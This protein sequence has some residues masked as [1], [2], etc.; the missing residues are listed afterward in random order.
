MWSQ[1]F[2]TVMQRF[3]YVF[4][5]KDNKGTNSVSQMYQTIEIDEK[6]YKGVN[7]CMTFPP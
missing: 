7:G 4:V 5:E 2:G 1:N 6:E 3:E